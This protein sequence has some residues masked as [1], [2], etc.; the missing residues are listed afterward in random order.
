MLAHA[1]D[2][3]VRAGVEKDGALEFIRPVIV[4]GQAAQARL[5]ASDDEGRVLV[6][7]ADQVAVDRDRVVGARARDAAGGVGVRV[8]AVLSDRVMVDHGVH[9][10]G[11]H[12]KAQTRLAQDLDA[13]GVAPVGLADDAHAV[14]V[15][16][17]HSGD[18]GHAKAGVVHI[19]VSADVDEVALIPAAGLHVRAGY[20]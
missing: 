12:K 15:R 1:V 8:P 3:K 10:A 17:E 4:V 6:G 13:C 16:L 11:G 20:G 5:D 9:V 19:G 14:T 2:Q 18:D 7:A